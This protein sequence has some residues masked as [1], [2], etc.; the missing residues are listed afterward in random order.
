MPNWCGSAKARRISRA[1]PLS[2][3][4]DR[5][6][7][8]FPAAD[9][10]GVRRGRW[11]RRS[12]E[13]YQENK[14]SE[15]NLFSRCIGAISGPSPTLSENKSDPITLNQMTLA[16]IRFIYPST[17]SDAQLIVSHPKSSHRRF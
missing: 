10:S 7:R 14:A 16:D 11:G 2:R 5:V 1:N 13:K 4:T 17:S 3:P 6:H 15:K 8:I 9:G 12:I